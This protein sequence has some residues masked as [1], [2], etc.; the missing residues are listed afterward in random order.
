MNIN[1]RT[2]LLLAAATAG[3]DCG[4]NACTMNAMIIIILCKVDRESER[5]R[6][7]WQLV[8][9]KKFGVCVGMP[10]MSMQRTRPRARFMT[11]TQ[12]A[13]THTHSGQ[14]AARRVRHQGSELAHTH[15]SVF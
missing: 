4:K 3:A 13:H 12:G 15:A 5:R 8:E 10:L 1:K 6:T 14:D 2:E 7:T 11:T 9:L